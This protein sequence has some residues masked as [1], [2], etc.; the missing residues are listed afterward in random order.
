[1]ITRCVHPPD[2]PC[3]HPR[4]PLR[5]QGSTVGGEHTPVQARSTSVG[6]VREGRP[7][8]GEPVEPCEREG[9]RAYI[10]E[11]GDGFL[12]G[13]RNDGWGVVVPA[14]LVL[15]ETGSGYPEGGMGR[16]LPR[17]PGMDSCSGA[18][19]V[20]AVVVRPAD[21]AP[22]GPRGGRM[23]RGL[24]RAPGMDSCLR[25][26]GG[27]GRGPPVRGEPVEPCERGLPAGM[28]REV[29]AGEPPL[30]AQGSTRSWPLRLLRAQ[31]CP[32]G[33]PSCPRTGR[34][35]GPF[36]ELGARRGEPVEPCEWQLRGF[37][38]GA[39]VRGEP[40]DPCEGEWGGAS[41]SPR[42]QDA[43]YPFSANLPDRYL[44]MTLDSSV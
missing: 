15:V 7:V 5:K 8:R 38:Y 22:R 11:G 34:G 32:F 25:R 42:R 24:P 3:V 29:G 40:V 39:L 14:K 27:W 21:I 18:G 10:E 44:W 19:M 31:E 28:V 43:R 13:G 30:H 9:A 17:A 6:A 1:M 2:H 26:K 20:G 36:L 4:P 33:A 16:G 37:R 23:G 35:A 12:L 41:E